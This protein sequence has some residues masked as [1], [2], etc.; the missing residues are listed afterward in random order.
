MQNEFELAEYT[1]IQLAYGRCVPLT[2][3]FAPHALQVAAY[4]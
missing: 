3:C 4:K 2:R 1:G